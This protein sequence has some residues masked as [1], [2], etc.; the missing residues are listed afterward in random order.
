VHP[1]FVVAFAE[2][3]PSFT[4]VIVPVI[5]VPLN[6][7]QTANSCAILLHALAKYQ[8]VQE[9]LSEEITSVLGNATEATPQHLSQMPYLKGCI[10]ES[11]RCVL[12]SLLL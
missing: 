1:V 7:L 2:H 12:Y 3:L 10:L 11:F 5:V 4:M 9:R 8:E 6:Y